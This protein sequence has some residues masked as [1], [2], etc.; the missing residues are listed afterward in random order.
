MLLR[1]P[2]FNQ[3]LL[4]LL[5]GSRW[6]VKALTYRISSYPKTTLKQADVDKELANAF[7]VWSDHTDLTFTAKK[8]GQVTFLVEMIHRK[9]REIT[10][11]FGSIYI[12]NLYINTGLI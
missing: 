8:S 10:I 7:K 1:T 12:L 5:T 11:Y 6:R 2:N 9:I 3:K 4:I